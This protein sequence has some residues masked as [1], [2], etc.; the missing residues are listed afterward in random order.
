[1]ILKVTKKQAFNL[2]L[3]LESTFFEKTIEVGQIDSTN[4]FN[5][6]KD[7]TMF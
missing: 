6:E 5:V 3:S 1:M 2:S 4:L 7:Q